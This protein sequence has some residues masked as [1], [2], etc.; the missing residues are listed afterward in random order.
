VWSER[1]DGVCSSCDAALGPL[2]VA[3]KLWGNLRTAGT[4]AWSVFTETME[5][6]GMSKS[7]AGVKGLQQD[8]F[9]KFLDVRAER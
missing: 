6:E 7:L 8:F 5:A 9:Q 3:G 1:G 4:D 2:G